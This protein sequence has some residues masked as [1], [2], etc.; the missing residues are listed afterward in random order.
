MAYIGLRNWERVP[1]RNRVQIWRTEELLG[2][3]HC[4]SKWFIFHV[5]MRSIIREVLQKCFHQGKSNLQSPVFLYVLQK[6]RRGE[7]VPFR[8]WRP[9]SNHMVW[10]VLPQS[11]V[12]TD[13]K[14]SE[15]GSWWTALGPSTWCYDK[16]N[17]VGSSNG[18]GRG[19]PKSRILAGASTWYGKFWDVR[20]AHGERTSGK[21]W[22]FRLNTWLSSDFSA[23]LVIAKIVSA[24]K[25][26]EWLGGRGG[27]YLRR[28]TSIL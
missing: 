16:S 9:R 19:S 12:G 10:L 28:H 27:G 18:C 6:T 11:D 8:S 20:D 13:K 25:S 24:W 4:R 23:W 21:D 22:Q 7:A 2:L 17:I 15:E 14:C 5:K 3:S 26:Q 1:F